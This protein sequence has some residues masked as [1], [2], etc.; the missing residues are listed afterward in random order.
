MISN[1]TTT[2]NEIRDKDGVAATVCGGS[3]VRTG[4]AAHRDLEVAFVDLVTGLHMRGSSATQYLQELYARYAGHA[5]AI[6]VTLITQTT[7]NHSYGYFQTSNSYFICTDA[8]KIDAIFDRLRHFP[9][10]NVSPTHTEAIYPHTIGGLSIRSIRDLTTGFGY[11]SSNPSTFTPSLPLSSGHMITFGAGDAIS[12]GA[13]I[14]LT[15]RWVQLFI[16][17]LMACS[18]PLEG[19][20]LPRVGTTTLLNFLALF[21]F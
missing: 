18:V 1:E 16:Y 20:G 21:L 12:D 7:A 13:A 3:S 11:D 8:A 17:R 9:G 4:P 14:T 15:I 19:L 10:E 2:G 6:A 5:P